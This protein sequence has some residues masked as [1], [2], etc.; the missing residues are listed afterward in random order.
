V[1]RI[2]DD[3]PITRLSAVDQATLRDLLA[4]ITDPIELP[5]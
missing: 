1:E 4:K 2:V 3:A 5:E